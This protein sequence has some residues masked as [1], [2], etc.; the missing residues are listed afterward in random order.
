[1]RL[2]A[3]FVKCQTLSLV[4]TWAAGYHGAMTRKTC[5]AFLLFMAPLAACTDVVSVEPPGG[6]I[7]ADG[8]G[9]SDPLG[10]QDPASEMSPKT[11]GRA[12]RPSTEH[13]VVILTP[14]VE[15]KSLRLR[16]TPVSQDLTPKGPS[17]QSVVMVSAQGPKIA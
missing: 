3:P 16:T 17:P 7:G 8:W 15:A 6:Q 9:T 14:T 5:I 2:R 12:G 13:Q 10:R 4:A 1:M 11:R